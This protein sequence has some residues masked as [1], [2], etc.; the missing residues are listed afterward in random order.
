MQL[1]AVLWK[2]SSYYI[3]L[4][5]LRVLATSLPMLPIYKFSGMF[6]FEPRV[7]AAIASGRATN[8]APIP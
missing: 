1:Y 7:G 4:T 2:H 6:G 5:A 3:I 8:L